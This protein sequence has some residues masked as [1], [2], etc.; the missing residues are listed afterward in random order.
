MV[1][2]AVNSPAASAPSEIASWFGLLAAPLPAVSSERDRDSGQH[3]VGERVGHQ[4]HSAEDH[5][6]ADDAAEHADRGGRERPVAHELRLERL[7][8]PV[9]SPAPWW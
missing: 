9:H 3:A 8:E 6:A 2:S 1:A 5:V 4:R 7:D